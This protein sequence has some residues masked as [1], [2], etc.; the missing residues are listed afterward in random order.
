MQPQGQS[1]EPAAPLLLLPS[2]PTGTPA[3]T[4]FPIPSHIQLI[5]AKANCF[6]GSYNS[7]TS[8]GKINLHLFLLHPSCWKTHSTSV[9]C[10]LPALNDH[11]NQFAA[12]ALANKG[13]SELKNTTFFLSFC[14]QWAATLTSHKEQEKKEQKITLL[15]EV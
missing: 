14:R 12:A 8:P 4:D 7:S 13:M 10:Q 9:H 6:G 15:E 3:D 11:C 1:Q 2:Q 5:T